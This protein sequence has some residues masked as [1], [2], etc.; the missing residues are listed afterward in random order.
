L[1]PAASKPKTNPASAPIT[2]A[3][4]RDQKMTNSAKLK[5]ATTVRIFQIFTFAAAPWTRL[6]S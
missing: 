2:T 6:P 3:F 5:K 4:C 1:V